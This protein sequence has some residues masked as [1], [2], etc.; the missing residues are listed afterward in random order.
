MT[1]GARKYVLRVAPPSGRYGYDYVHAGLGM[2]AHQH[3]RCPVANNY[4]VM[5]APLRCAVGCPQVCVNESPYMTQ[6]V[7]QDGRKMA[8]AGELHA[9]D[10]PGPRSAS[11]PRIWRARM[12][13][14]GPMR[15]AC[16]RIQ[17]CSR[18]TSHG[19]QRGVALLAVADGHCRQHRPWPKG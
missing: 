2:G 4:W 9:V 5:S 13:A 16:N 1:Q 19:S 14:A 15:F 10:S 7:A 8:S 12:E 3:M 6:A 17:S 18:Q 11:V